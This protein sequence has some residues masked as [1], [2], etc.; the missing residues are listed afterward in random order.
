MPDIDSERITRI[1]SKIDALNDKINDL[2]LKYQLEIANHRHTQ[3]M[4]KF[5]ITLLGVLNSLFI[6]LIGLKII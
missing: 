5:T 2:N 3:N 4:A 6:S 1:E